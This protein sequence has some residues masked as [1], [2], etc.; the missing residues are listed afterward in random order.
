MT[1][2]ILLRLRADLPEAAFRPLTDAYLEEPRGRFHGQAI[3]V[4]APASV[5]EVGAVVTLAAEFG[6]PVLPYSGGTGLVGG[7]LAEDG[8]MPVVLSLERMNR[9]REVYPSENVL[10]CDA[11]V[12]LADVQKAA[13]DVGRLF[14]VDGTTCAGSLTEARPK[15]HH[16]PMPLIYCKIVPTSSTSDEREENVY[17]CPVYYTSARGAT[18]LFA[19][20]LNTD[21]GGLSCRQAILRGTAL[22]LSTPD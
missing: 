14:D 8:P 19:A 22:V 10:V 18:Y 20:G 4:V 11:G 3:C 2:P 21:D 12:I 13:E 5:E 6:T 9:I 16:A 1:E 15:E 7:Q 17:E